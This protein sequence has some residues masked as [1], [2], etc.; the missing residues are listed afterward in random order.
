MKS[1]KTI[2]IVF[3]V[4]VLLGAGA[5]AVALYK[6]RHLPDTHDLEAQVD[7]V[8]HK[9][10][11]R[12]GIPV[13]MVAVVKDGQQY[14]KTYGTQEDRPGADALF[15]IGSITKLFTSLLVQRLVDQGTCKW[16]DPI[17]RFFPE[18]SG[19]PQDD[20]TM[21]LH[22]ATHTSGYPK[23]PPSFLRS[24]GND[25]DPYAR[26]TFDD[27]MNMVAQAEDKRAPDMTRVEY[28]N[29]GTGLLGHLMELHQGKTYDDL[30]ATHVTGPLG[31]E[32]T[33]STVDAA[34]AHLLLKG[35]DEA[36]RPTAP[37]NWGALQGAGALRSSITD[38]TKFLI[39]AVEKDPALGSAWDACYQQR[40]K[41]SGGG[42]GLGWHIDTWSGTLF[43][44]PRILWH[45]GGT[46]GFSSYLGI[47][48]ET[49]LGVVILANRLAP[50][51]VDKLGTDILLRANHIS[52]AGGS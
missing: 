38:M 17:V 22:L 30:L 14:I 11:E 49:G 24:V 31:M 5:L 41:T 28:S 32:L 45:N 9:A 47:V 20:G 37:W 19:P 15:E 3:G 4:L 13:L 35:H 40:V 46:G 25:P 42:V 18:G 36:G 6:M 16:E 50:S 27:L 7:E 1:L 29:F 44:M 48:P 52:F 51:V 21:L 39:A 43:N 26:L 2:G 33:R 34:Y 23:L 8:A 10:V 12:G